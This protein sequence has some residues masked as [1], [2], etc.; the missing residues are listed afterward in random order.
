MSAAVLV[1]T[2]VAAGV[3][4]LLRPGHL[5][6]VLGFVLLGH[7][8]NVVLLAAG[9]LGRRTA[10]VHEVGP[11]TADPLPQ[12]FVLT[13]IVITFGVTVY[14]LSLLRRGTADPDADDDGPG[15]LTDP[16][17]PGETDADERDGD[18]GPWAG[19]ARTGPDGGRR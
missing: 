1:G 6:V 14:L 10:A 18:G 19:P 13:A 9:G 12:A 15:G 2:L 16:D 4:L 7:A 5:R 17:G 11:D 3:F 8:V